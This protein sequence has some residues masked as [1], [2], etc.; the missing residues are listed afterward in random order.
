MGK[1]RKQFYLDPEQDAKLR[2][3]AM[4]W[5]R[6][7]AGVL[8]IALD[9]LADGDLEPEDVDEVLSDEELEALEAENEAWF[10][11]HPQPLRL[12]EAV[13]QDREGR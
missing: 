1:I 6:S 7:E 12:S 9:R 5:G 13:F 2:D 10:R 3:L 4:R 8:R 11:D